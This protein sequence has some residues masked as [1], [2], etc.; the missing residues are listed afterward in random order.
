MPTY[1]MNATIP[2]RGPCRTFRRDRWRH[3]ADTDAG[4]L[5]YRKPD[6]Q[7]AQTNDNAEFRD[8]HNRA[9]GG[10]VMIPCSPGKTIAV[11]TDAQQATRDCFVKIRSGTAKAP[12][13]QA[14][15]RSFTLFI[16]KAQQ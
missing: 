14:L 2:A 9:F 7:V 5:N 8:L 1:L 6:V 4:Q 11:S 15:A 3:R 16:N 10:E 12:V 13:A